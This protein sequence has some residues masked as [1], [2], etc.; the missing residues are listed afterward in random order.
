MIARQGVYVGFASV[1]GLGGPRVVQFLP[2]GEGGAI[3]GAAVRLDPRVDLRRHSPDGFTWGY[4]GAGPAQLA[5]AMLA[6]FFRDAH[7]CGKCDPVAG[8]CFDVIGHA[9][10]SDRRALQFYQAFKSARIATAT[11]TADLVIFASEIREWVDA[12]TCDGCGGLVHG[13][14]C[15]PRDDE[16]EP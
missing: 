4:A 13:G 11:P 16:A 10:A 8:I 15:D 9:A 2:M 6:H 12:H 7:R 3:V 1:P 14:A 5:L